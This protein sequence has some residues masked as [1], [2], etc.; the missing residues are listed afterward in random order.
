MSRRDGRVEWFVECIGLASNEAL[1]RALNEIGIGD[2]EAKYPDMPVSNGRTLDLI[3]IPSRHIRKLREEMRG[4]SSLKFRFFK[5]NGSRGP[6]SSAD[7][8]MRRRKSRHYKRVAEG[9][10]RIQSGKK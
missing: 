6:V 5:R 2:A 4:N 3:R 1:A 8:V 10:K 9:L 7:F